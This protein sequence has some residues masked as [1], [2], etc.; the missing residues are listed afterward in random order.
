MTNYQRLLEKD[1][2]HFGSMIILKL[3]NDV[4]KVPHKRIVLQSVARICNVVCGFPVVSCDVPVWKGQVD[5]PNPKAVNWKL[6]QGKR[7]F[8]ENQLKISPCVIRKTDCDLA[9]IF[10]SLHF[11]L[12][13]YILPD[14]LNIMA[15]LCVDARFLTVASEPERCQAAQKSLQ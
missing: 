3:I 14:P 8:S 6:S 4:R 12:I 10:R 1:L 7:G 5:L 15:D 9:N 11:L 2:W 13:N